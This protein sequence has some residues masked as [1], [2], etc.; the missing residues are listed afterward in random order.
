M[1]AFLTLLCGPA[2]ADVVYTGHVSYMA[3]MGS[4]SG[5]LYP[6]VSIDT[7][8]AFTMRNIHVGV[9]INS[10]LHNGLYYEGQSDSSW[11]NDCVSENTCIQGDS[12]I[13]SIGPFAGLRIGNPKKTHY[14][15]YAALQLTSIPLLMSED[16]YRSEVVGSW[17][18]IESPFHK[19][20]KT[21]LR[22]GVNILF[23]MWEE[24]PKFSIQPHVNYI[25]N[26]DLFWGLGLGFS[27]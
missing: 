27:I 12:L 5:I 13:S 4:L 21:N 20:L 22:M 24:G 10:A 26:V 18:G 7:R 1:F 19:G 3:P 8:I 15:P 17:G 23:P 9:S 2:K 6:G 16:Y 14:L 11:G 25:L